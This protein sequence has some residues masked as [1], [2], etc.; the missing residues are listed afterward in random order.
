MKQNQILENTKKMTDR[1][2]EL[3]QSVIEKSKKL[4]TPSPKIDKIGTTIGYVASTSLLIGGV[5]QIIVEN[6]LGH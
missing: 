6:Q 3:T 1:S 4:R 5:I 2:L